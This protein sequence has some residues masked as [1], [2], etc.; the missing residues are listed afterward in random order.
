MQHSTPRRALQLLDAGDAAGKQRVRA[1]GA[2]GGLPLLHKLF[3]Y[4]LADIVEIFFVPKASGHPAAF[5]LRTGDF[6]SEAP[7][8]FDRDGWVADGA[9]LAM[10][11]V[12]DSGSRRK[13]SNVKNRSRIASLFRKMPRKELH[14]IYRGILQL[15]ECFRRQ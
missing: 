3:G 11:V 2:F 12:E 5:H 1:L 6:K 7:Q 15:H 4:G 10:G 13:L 9:L 8:K 14:Q